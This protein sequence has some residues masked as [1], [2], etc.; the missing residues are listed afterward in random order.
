MWNP[1]PLLL[2]HQEGLGILASLIA[3]GGFFWSFG[4]RLM[5]AII[6]WFRSITEEARGAPNSK[7][8]RHPVLVQP[9]DHRQ[10]WWRD[11]QG[12]KPT[13]EILVSLLLTNLESKEIEMSRAILRR[14]KHWLSWDEQPGDLSL[15]DPLIHNREYFDRIL[16]PRHVIN[17]RGGWRLLAPSASRKPLVIRILV[18]DQLGRRSASPRISVPWINDPRRVF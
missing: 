14:R 1:E 17:G 12:D 5:V 15:T 18:I 9:G 3:I 16:P 4:R 11:I 10:M 6:R 13:I 8:S 7:S 2:T